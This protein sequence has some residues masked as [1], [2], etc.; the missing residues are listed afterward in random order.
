M[1]LFLSFVAGPSM[2]TVDGMAYEKPCGLGTFIY[3]PH[4]SGAIDKR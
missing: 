2:M 1:Y 3:P 4:P